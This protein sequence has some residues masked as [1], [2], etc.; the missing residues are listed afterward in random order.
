M[1]F[2]MKIYFLLT[3]E[4]LLNRLSLNACFRVFYIWTI[5]KKTYFTWRCVRLQLCCS[6]TRYSYTNISARFLEYII[7]RRKYY[8]FSTVF[9]NQMCYTGT[10]S[11]APQQTTPLNDARMFAPCSQAAWYLI[12]YMSVSVGHLYKKLLHNVCFTTHLIRRQFQE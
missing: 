4:R 1:C 3:T 6:V 7:E 9:S 2:K 11:T 5:S 8:F 10:M 12:S